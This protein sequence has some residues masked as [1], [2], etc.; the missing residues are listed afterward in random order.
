MKI[1]DQSV[2]VLY[3]GTLEE[4]INELKKIE[5]AGRNCWRSEGKITDDSYK[6]FVQGLIKR[7]H[8]S[9]LEFGEIMFEIITSRD[10]LAEITRHRIASFAVESQRYVNESREDGG[11]KFIKPLFF[12]QYD[13]YYESDLYDNGY[14]SDEYYR[15]YDASRKWEKTMLY[16]EDVYNNLIEM[17]MKNQ[18]ARKVLP[19][20]TACT[21][22]M[23][24]NL[25]ELLHMYKLRSSPAAYPEMQ[26]MMRLLKIEVDK[27]LPGFLPEK[28]S[29]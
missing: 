1:I 5:I 3:P 27:V 16:I 24:V 4:G 7:G 11:I 19:N 8:D 12:K 20:S 22:M 2:R 21:I 28:E 23:K 15:T 29:V 14:D 6:S 13:P 18:D 25:R 9:P 10:V 26:A 17:G